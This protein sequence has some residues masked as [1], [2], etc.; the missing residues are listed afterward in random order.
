VPA[1]IKTLCIFKAVGGVVAAI[2]KV[3]TVLGATKCIR[4]GNP[5]N[6]LPVHLH[7]GFALLISNLLLLLAVHVS[8]IITASVS[9]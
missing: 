6:I 3:L 1:S 9:V 4:K 2:A 8:E 5:V 7:I